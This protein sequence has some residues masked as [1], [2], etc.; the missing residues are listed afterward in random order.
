MKTSGWQ[1]NCIL[2]ARYWGSKNIFILWGLMKISDLFLKCF[3]SLRSIV[4][5]STIF[6]VFLIG[7]SDVHLEVPEV[8]DPVVQSKGGFCI[9]KPDEIIKYTKFLFVIDKSGSNRTM[10]P[11]GQKRSANIRDFVLGNSHETSFRYAMVSFG[12]GAQAYTFDKL[13]QPGFTDSNQVML[14]ATQKMQSDSDNGK[15]PYKAGLQLSEE[16]I[17][18]DV[19][20]F[21]DEESRYV[22]FF[23]SDGEPTD[24]SSD[25]G[26]GFNTALLDSLVT[27]LISVEGK[28]IYLSS[29]YY[30]G[31]GAK[32]QS[33]LKRMAEKGNGKYV[34]FEEN[35]HWDFNDL[36]V[37]PDVQ[38]WQLKT[39]LV[40]NVSDGFC[41]DHSIDVDSDADGM[42]DKDELR[43]QELGFDPAK[44]FSFGGGY[45][46]YFHWLRMKHGKELPPCDDRSD[47]DHDLLTRCEEDFIENTQPSNPTNRTHGDRLNPDTDFD[48]IID[49][50]E[51]FVFFTRSRSFAMDDRNLSSVQYDFEEQAG[52]QIYQHRNPLIK[53]PDAQ[54][55]D[56]EYSPILEDETKTC[57]DFTM[58][59]LPLKQTIEVKAGDT[60]PGLEHK[61]GENIVLLYYMQSYQNDPNGI[62][63]YSYSFQKLMKNNLRTTSETGLKVDDSVFTV[64]IPSTGAR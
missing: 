10:D 41:I 59:T 34:N 44:R 25:T 49:G 4:F 18:N 52:Q 62:F 16:V 58:S 63:T 5:L 51:T 42:C 1:M 46:D 64:Y 39:L 26:G 31:N 53:D 48:G 7:C 60:L 24:I 32:A 61:A 6:F 33:L 8:V 2:I 14:E 20:L 56:A 47:E 3:R 37:K 38:P 17:Q 22:I 11:G 43:L 19:K 40:Y 21:P 35:E 13:G 9:S 45:G 23:I 54:A 50:V 28:D 12:I 27:N 15:T 36:V 57:Y 55:Y 30:G 29:A